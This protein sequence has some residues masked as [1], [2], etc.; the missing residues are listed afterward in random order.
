M[1]VKVGIGYIELLHTEIENLGEIAICS[2]HA[3]AGGKPLA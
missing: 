3:G 1:E 2:F